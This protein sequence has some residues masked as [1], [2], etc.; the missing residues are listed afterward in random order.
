MREGIDILS[1]THNLPIPLSFPLPLSFTL[2]L[3][4]LS[5][6]VPLSQSPSLPLALT[7]SLFP[8]WLLCSVLWWSA[9]SFPPRWTVISENRNQIQ[10]FH[11]NLRSQHKFSYHLGWLHCLRGQPILWVRATVHITRIRLGKVVG[12]CVKGEVWREG[13]QIL[14]RVAIKG[15]LPQ[16]DGMFCFI[17]FC[18][19]TG[20]HC[21]VL[22]ILELT[23]YTR[24]A[25]HSQRSACLWWD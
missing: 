23:M 20:L 8:S 5:L 16:N 4:L 3:P 15:A 24:L 9:M 1:P 17:L 25:L 6:P 12:V 7:L 2:S 10:G 11:H 18:F 19:E 13:L 22:D 21:V 14:I